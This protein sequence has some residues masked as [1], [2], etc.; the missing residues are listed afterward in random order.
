[1]IKKKVI[2]PEKV[3]RIQ[4][5]FSFVPHRFLKDGFLASLDPDEILLYLFLVLASDKN[6]L[7]FYGEPKICAILQL[8]EDQFILVRQKLI[9]RKLIAWDGEIYQVLELPQ[10]PVHIDDSLCQKPLIEPE[11]EKR[12]TG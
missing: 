6:G 11:K 3:R 8:K 2:V 1:M 7:S 12:R 10:K 9:A 5:G 4:G